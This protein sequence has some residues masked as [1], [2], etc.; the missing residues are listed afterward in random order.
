MPRHPGGCLD[1]EC[2]SNACEELRIHRAPIASGELVVATRGVD[3]SYDCERVSSRSTGMG[4]VRMG[5][6]S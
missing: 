5:S 6:R 3:V 1:M 2:H 4:A